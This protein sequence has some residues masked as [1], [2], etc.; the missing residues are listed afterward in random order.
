MLVE[1]LKSKLHKATV[2]GADL[3]YEGSISIDPQLYRQA[4]MYTYEKVDIFNV[5]TGARFSTYIIEGKPG[6][7][8]LNGA[9]ARL[10]A[11]GDRVIIV[12]YTQVESEQAEGWKPTV[13][14]LGERN[15]PA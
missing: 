6:E 5:N 10:V 12:S 11:V 9:A 15:I 1:V 14:L 13:V 4:G 7:V 2:T 3:H 8:C